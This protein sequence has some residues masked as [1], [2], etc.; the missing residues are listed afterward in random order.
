[1]LLDFFGAYFTMDKSYLFFDIECANCFDGNGKMCS[2]GYVLTDASFS[3]LDT[4]DVVMNPETEFDWYL[5]S[6]KNKCPL[7]YS[8][9][10]FRAQPNFE[11]F[12]PNLKKLLEAP[13]RRVIGFSS[14]NDVGFLVYA[15]E[16]YEFDIFNFAAFD[17]A[18]VLKLAKN[19]SHTLEDWC[20]RYHIDRAGLKAH[21]SCDDAMMTMLLT[22]AF[23][24]EQGIT[25]DTLLST[26]KSTKLS[27]EKY[28]E[29]REISRHNKENMNKI[30]DLFGKKSK[31]PL[32]KKLAGSLF[33]FGFKIQNDTD[34]AL[35]LGQLVFK[36]GGMLQKHLKDTGF[37]LIY[38]DMDSPEVIA[39]IEKR[40][41]IPLKLSDFYEKVKME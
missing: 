21:R 11:S 31:A 25:I 28:I 22:K 18:A 7:S 33:A 35:K 39:G 19:E 15:C 16:R 14:P 27:V 32:T 10:Y 17:I 3:V 2:F 1:R 41:L 4:D 23:C 40:G 5:F 37:V 26:Y 12:Y 36:H 38:D 9:D 20:D 30:K 8:K 6:P 24:E 34:T 29:Q 13:D